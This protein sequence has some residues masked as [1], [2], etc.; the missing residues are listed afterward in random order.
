MVAEP[1]VTYTDFILAAESFL[2]TWLLVREQAS[3]Q[4]LRAWFAIF[5]AA[6]GVAALAG[7]TVH[8]FLTDP[9]S[10][11]H[12]IVWRLTMLA[13]GA[14][15]LAAWRIGADL[16]AVPAVARWITVL[17]AV[18]FAAYAAIVV[19]IT[20]DFKVAVFNYLPSAVFLLIVLLIVLARAETGALWLALA[21]LLLTFAAAAVQRLEF[22]AMGMTYNALYHLVQG[23]GLLLLFLGAAGILKSQ[24]VN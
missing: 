14:A 21:G 11:S 10:W 22:G 24:A 9:A 17:A 3:N 8:G 2:F 1:D 20:D 18:Q 16:L 4:S 5:F 13:I 6:L 12:K 7:G 19:L 15:T 23:A